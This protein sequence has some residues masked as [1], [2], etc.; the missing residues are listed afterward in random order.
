MTVED[1]KMIQSEKSV[2]SEETFSEVFEEENEFTRQQLIEALREKASEL[3]C[4]KKFDELLNAYKRFNRQIVR[5]QKQ[6]ELAEMKR[7]P[8]DNMTEFDYFDDGHELCC[9]AWTADKF[10]VIGHDIRGDYLA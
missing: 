6:N 1:I 7:G 4:K 2:L 5:Q 3:K 10:G 8:R 9:G